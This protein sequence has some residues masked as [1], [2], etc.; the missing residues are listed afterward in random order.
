MK[1]FR[2]EISTWVQFITFILLWGI[3]LVFSQTDLTKYLDVLKKVPDAIA[4]YGICYLVF[5]KWLWRLSLLQGWLV[6]FPDLQGT[7][8]GTLQTT[9][10]DADGNTPA[11]IPLLLVIRQSFD[12]INCVMHTKESSSVSNAALLSEDIGSGLHCLSYNYTNKPDAAI[13]GRSAVHDGAALLTVIK[14]PVKMLK[15][16]YWTNRKTT[17]SIKLKFKSRE[18]KECFPESKEVN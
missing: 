14:K 16:E 1:N 17:G 15:G 11:P 8:E 9:W 3:I 2:K 6:P 7:W 12:S 5:T 18:L 13:R 10:K 4:A